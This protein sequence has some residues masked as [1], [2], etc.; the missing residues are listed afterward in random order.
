LT[1]T[2]GAGEATGVASPIQ[3]AASPNPPSRD[4][5]LESCC[6]THAPVRCCDSTALQRGQCQQVRIETFGSSGGRS[7]AHTHKRPFRDA[8]RCTSP[9]L[10]TI[11]TCTR[12]TRTF[13]I[14]PSFKDHFLSRPC[15]TLHFVVAVRSPTVRAV[16]TRGVR[17]TPAPP[18]RASQP[19]A[20]SRGG[21]APRA[22][23]PGTRTA[24]RGWR[25]TARAP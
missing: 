25:W 8:R 17:D 4:A 10:K 16:R 22:R 13:G 23:R 11:L 21:A 1:I 7:I 9:G 5:R 14:C 2:R 6:A 18:A 12:T 15:Q 20:V 3:S 19:Q 24:A